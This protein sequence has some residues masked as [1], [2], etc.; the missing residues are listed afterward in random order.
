MNGYWEKKRG[1]TEDDLIEKNIEHQKGAELTA[2]GFVREIVAINSAI[3]PIW[4]LNTLVR[5]WASSEA[6][7]AFNSN[8]SFGN[9]KEKFWFS[10]KWRNYEIFEKLWKAWDKIIR[11]ILKIDWLSL[12]LS[13]WKFF[14][15]LRINRKIVFLKQNL[16]LGRKIWKP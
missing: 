9:W 15:S 8:F 1:K 13:L 6:C 11:E 3:T 12:F 10:N 2:V 4:L 7:L 16:I 5:F 14:R